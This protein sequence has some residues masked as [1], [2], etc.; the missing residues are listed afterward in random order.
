[1]KTI[2]YKGPNGLTCIEKNVLS[3][4]EKEA[5]LNTQDVCGIHRCFTGKSHGS[6]RMLGFN[7]KHIDKSPE[8]VMKITPEHLERLKKSIESKRNRENIK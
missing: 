5:R 6:K 4:I 2:E 1:M 7:P 3:V 8:V